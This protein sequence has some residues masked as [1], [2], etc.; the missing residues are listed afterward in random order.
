MQ[1]ASQQKI[2]LAFAVKKKPVSKNSETLKFPSWSDM[3]SHQG[4]L[5]FKRLFRESWMTSV[6]S[7]KLQPHRC[8][9]SCNRLSHQARCETRQRPAADGAN[10]SL[11]FKNSR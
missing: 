7:A 5:T 9:W 3:A 10:F 1:T 2:E 8:P 4:K 6:P 11:F